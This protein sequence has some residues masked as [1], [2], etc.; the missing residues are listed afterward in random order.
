MADI[1]FREE[2]YKIV[3]AA[4]EVHKVLGCGFVEAVYQEALAE[5]FKRRDIPYERE[6]EL[7]II[8]KDTILSKTFRVDFL[9]YNNIILELKAVTDLTDEHYSQLYSYLKASN[10]DLGLLI[11]F[12]RSTLIYHRLPASQKWS[13]WKRTR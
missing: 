4:M 6:K 10:L 1:L 7:A 12:G 13:S 9:C 8:Y 5:E 11:N 3:G 2:S